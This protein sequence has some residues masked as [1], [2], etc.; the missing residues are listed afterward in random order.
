M[1]KKRLEYLDMAKGVGILLVV[2]VHSK[3][4]PEKVTAWL[5]QPAMPLFFVVAGMLI[6]CTGEI[7]KNGKELVRKKSRSLLVPYFWFTLLYVL[8]DLVNISLGIADEAALKV[9]I[10]AF[11]T[12]YGCSVLWFLSTLFFAE[13]TFIFLRKKCSTVWTLLL[14]LIL[15]VVSFFVNGLLPGQEAATQAAGVLCYLTYFVRG[16]LRSAYALPFLCIG[17]YLFER[18]PGFW[19]EEKK[20]SLWQSGGGVLLIGFGI[21]LYRFQTAFDFRTLV[22]GERPVFTYLLA[23]IFVA[24]ILLI[25]KN[26]RPIK[27]LLYFGKNSL[28]IMATHMDLNVLYAALS[29]AYRIN[30]FIPRFNR[31]FFFVNVMGVTLL[32]EVVCITLVNRF[33][34]FFIGKKRRKEG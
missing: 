3:T 21:F 5:A 2:L 33:F 10:M 1:D 14:C 29:L 7:R 17:Y 6:A 4:L 19:G 18:F 8:R 22:M 16:L 26:C 31:V 13:L 34:P 30:P 32:I 11:V 9:E 25:C 23:F 12:L 15:T 28:I 24:G 27:P 20:F